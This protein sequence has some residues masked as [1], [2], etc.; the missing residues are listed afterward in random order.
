M[1]KYLYAHRQRTTK[2]EQLQTIPS[3]APHAN[4]QIIIIQSALEDNDLLLVGIAFLLVWCLRCYS[5]LLFTSYSLA[6]ST[7]SKS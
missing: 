4:Q 3:M 2:G 5:E 1:T 6:W 7:T